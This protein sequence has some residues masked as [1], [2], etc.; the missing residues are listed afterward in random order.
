MEDIILVG[1]GGHAKSVADCIER[2]G[3]YRIAGY[4]DNIQ[5]DSPYKYL[6]TD[7]VLPEYF[8]GGICN[9]AVGVGFVGKGNIRNRIYE[10][11]KKIGYKLPI[12]TDPSS[13][14]ASTAKLEEG[15]FVAKMAVI[16]V[17]ATVGKMSIINTGAIVEH[18]CMIGSFSHVAVGAKICGQVTT[19]KAVMVGAGTTIIQCL[20][21]GDHSIVGAGATVIKDVKENT[22]VVGCPAIKVKG[23]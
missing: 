22:L 17:E 14:I 21:I 13:I 3:K 19:G 12:I 7:E 16:N 20:N 15:V 8:D 9:A 2:Q 18:E 10:N 1:Y 4:T 5:H 23:L 6:G 11:L